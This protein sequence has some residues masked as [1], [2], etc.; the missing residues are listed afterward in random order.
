MRGIIKLQRQKH[1]LLLTA[2]EAAVHPSFTLF[3]KECDPHVAEF[4]IIQ[5]QAG[6]ESMV[7]MLIQRFL[8]WLGNV[9]CKLCR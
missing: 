1:R 9:S 3:R 4:K 5:T 2:A 8:Q 6:R 7:A